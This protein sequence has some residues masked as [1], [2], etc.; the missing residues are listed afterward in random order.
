MSTVFMVLGI[1]HWVGLAAIVG[2]YFLSL[3]RQVIHPVMLW[4]ARLQL[5]LGL[6]LVGVAEMGKVASFGHAWVAVKLV[7]ALAVVACCEIAAAR[8][9]KGAAAPMLIHAGF[10]LACVNFL[11]ASFW[12]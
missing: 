9:R 7:I 5:L 4:G 3:Q 10:V 2:G 12:E 1:L 8:T 11:I 6:A